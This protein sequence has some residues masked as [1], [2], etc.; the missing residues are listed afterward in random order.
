MARKG[1]LIAAGVIGVGALAAFGLK[2]ARAAPATAEP[3]KLA[4]VKKVTKPTVTRVALAAKFSKAFGV[5]T[6]L[7]LAAMAAL[8]GNKADAFHDNKRGGSW[9]LGQMTLATAK[10]IWPR[11]KAKIGK[12]WDGTGKGLLDPTINVGLT[13]YMLSLGWKRYAKNAKGWFLALCYYGLGPGR[14]QQLI[15]TPSTSKLPSPMPPDMVSLKTR[16]AAVLKSNSEVKNALK[17]E[18]RTP[19]LSGADAAY[20]KALSDQIPA[21]ITGFQARS[22]FGKM[23]TALHNAYGTLA[24]YDPSGIAQ[25]TKLD[26]GSVKAARQYLDS[27]NAMLTKYYPNMPESSAVLTTAQLNQL[28]LSVSSASN[29]AHLV[30]E[31]FKTPWT[32][33]LATDI[34]TAAQQIIEK[35]KDTLGLDKTTLAIA[36]AGVIGAAVLVTSLKK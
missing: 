35:T 12:T 13:A 3:K 14:T 24:N 7:V 11:A 5:P 29:A 26:A 15:P 33:E 6:S 1:P 20:G 10:E 4:P 19:Q 8:S 9:G 36:A 18:A 22:M 28:K 27:T 17:A 31:L 25:A 21:K 30:D 32:A 2:R 34:L 16:Y 23:T